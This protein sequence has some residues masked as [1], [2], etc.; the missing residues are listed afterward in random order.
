[1][2]DSTYLM[3][4]GG[5]TAAAAERGLHEVDAKGSI[6]VIG[7]EPHRPYARPPLS[8]AL[9]QGKPEESVWLEQPAGV[10]LLTGRR[11]VSIDRT[12]RRVTD[13]RGKSHGYRKLLLATGGWP[14]RLPY[15]EDA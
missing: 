8:K 13:D 10:E 2:P 14:R 6:A 15:G 7:D 1:M 9:W 11:A 5:M 4:G 3:V 12:A